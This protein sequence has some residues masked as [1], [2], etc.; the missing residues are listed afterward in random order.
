MTIAR[1]EF[2]AS[3]T[4]AGAAGLI[5]LRPGSAAAE[6]PPETSTIR[7]PHAPL[8]ACWA[9]LYVAEPLL[10]AE[11]FNRVEYVPIT[12]P[13]KPIDARHSGLNMALNAGEVDLSPND[14]PAHLLSLDAGGSAILLAGL[15]AGCQKLLAL[16][17]IRSV[18]DLKGK[19]VAVPN[20]GRRAFVMSIA[21]YIGLDPRK[22]IVWVDANVKDSMNM[23]ADEKVD[24][25]IGF[26]PE[27]EELLARK[28]GHVLVDTL[29]DKPWSQY[30]CCILAG[31]REFVRKNP[32][33]TKRALRA[34]LK[35]N[36]ICSA[37]PER[38]VQALVGRGYKRR[39]DIA[40]QLVRELPYGRWR[41]YD[42]EATVRFYALRLRETG[43][44][45]STP[46]KIIS[47]STDWSF[48]SALKKE[49][50]G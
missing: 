6:P 11:G 5:G 39:Q 18:R 22:D 40:L 29:T 10:H 34:I 12:G 32:V 31:N 37:D 46:Q 42:T 49:L 9:P 25:Y 2:V 41:D 19:A 38:A 23:L 20:L 35:A 48:I 43:M 17:R 50:K 7:F 45:T 15:H 24:A 1:R 21:S 27:P 30:F 44:I 13:L 26:A 16:G 14:S 28:V 3:M 33:A 8:L 47:S 36:E 4:A